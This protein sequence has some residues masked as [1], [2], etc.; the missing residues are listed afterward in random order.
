MGSL[1]KFEEEEMMDNYETS[2]SASSS[3]GHK[4]VPWLNWDEWLF[5]EYSLFSDSP[6]SVASAL[7]RV[8][9]HSEPQTRCF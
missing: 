6:E 8:K 3:S 9:S 1:L 5:V 2:S 4:L 7:K